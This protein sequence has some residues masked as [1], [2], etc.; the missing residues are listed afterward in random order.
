MIPTLFVFGGFLFIAL[1]VVLIVLEMILIATRNE[2]GG[3][4]YLFVFFLLWFL[5]GDL[6]LLIKESPLAIVW[7]PAL[8][9][10]VGVVWSFPKWVLFLASVRDKYRAELAEYRDKDNVP[11]DVPL[12]E[13]ARITS[14]YYFTDVGLSYDTK[15]GV[16][17]PPTFSKNKERIAGYIVL[18]PASIL[19]SLLG[20]V[21]ARIVRWLVKLFRKTYEA[22]SSWMFNFE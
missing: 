18:W 21:M 9:L 19:H 2:G 11:G 15:T 16:L 3:I 13:K 14:S 8:Y 1:L 17:T 5:F 22:L 7:M 12:S 4:I 6:G 20:D 10:L